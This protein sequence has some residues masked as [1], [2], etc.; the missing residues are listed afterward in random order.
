RTIEV[1]TVHVPNRAGTLADITE[2][3]A[4]SNVNIEG[5][6]GTGG[7]GG[8]GELIFKVSDL[9]SAEKIIGV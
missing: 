3:L 5:V 8:E 7:T 9:S 1:L 4:K 6:F 2:K